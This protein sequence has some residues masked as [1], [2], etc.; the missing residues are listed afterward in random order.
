[1]ES[2]AR[3][4]KI[5]EWHVELLCKE[6]TESHEEALASL[7]EKL[8]SKDHQ[9][10]NYLKALKKPSILKLHTALTPGSFMR[11]QRDEYR[12]KLFIFHHNTGT[13]EDPVGYHCARCLR[14]VKKGVIHD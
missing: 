1:M 10:G 6:L 14:R 13:D 5:H 11:G 12:T 9:A 3:R 2:N 8:T 7:L 4:A